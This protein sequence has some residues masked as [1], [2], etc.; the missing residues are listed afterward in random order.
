MIDA[1]ID[2]HLKGTLLVSQPAFRNMRAAGYGRIVSP[3]SASGLFGNFS[4]ANHGA[5]KA[6][7][8]GLTK[9]LALEGRLRGGTRRRQRRSGPG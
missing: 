5:A 6:G 7:I 8:G 4:Q 2:V 3:T 9:V 1:V